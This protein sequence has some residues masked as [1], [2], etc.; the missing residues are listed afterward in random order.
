MVDVMT[1]PFLRMYVC[2][3]GGLNSIGIKASG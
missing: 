1:L 2:F 3:E